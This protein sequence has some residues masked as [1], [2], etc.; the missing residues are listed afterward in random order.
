MV[1]YGRVPTWDIINPTVQS[2]LSV[3]VQG[4]PPATLGAIAHG[5]PRSYSA[6]VP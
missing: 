4:V 2:W 5:L 1:S 6:H 3:A